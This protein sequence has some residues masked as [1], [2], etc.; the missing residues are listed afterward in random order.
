[1]LSVVVIHQGGD[2]RP[3]PGFFKLA[4]ELGKDAHDREAFWQ[5]EFGRVRVAWAQMRPARPGH[6]IEPNL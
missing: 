4:Q 1:M 2:M 5:A 6:L 3:G